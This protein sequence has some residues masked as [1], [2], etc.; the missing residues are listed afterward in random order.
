MR[1]SRVYCSAP[2]RTLPHPTVSTKSA[3]A[4][5]EKPAEMV[6]LTQH[7]TAKGSPRSSRSVK[8]CSLYASTKPFVSSD[9]TTVARPSSGSTTLHGGG[10]GGVRRCSAVVG[11]GEASSQHTVYEPYAAGSCP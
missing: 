9:V 2:Y 8:P 10:G 1:A 4:L 3:G 11:G 7:W 5:E 6:A